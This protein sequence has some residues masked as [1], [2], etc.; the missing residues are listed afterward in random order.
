ML[1]YKPAFLHS[2]LSQARTRREW[3]QRAEYE[4]SYTVQMDSVIDKTQQ[5]TVG[6]SV[7]GLLSGKSRKE[8]RQCAGLL[9][10]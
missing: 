8:Y 5:E 2:G 4:R 3:F 9:D 1:A 6:P 7:S 10:T